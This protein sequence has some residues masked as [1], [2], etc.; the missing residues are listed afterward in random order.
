L[1]AVPY[2]ERDHKVLGV[3]CCAYGTRIVTLFSGS[4]YK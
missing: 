1:A 4:F 2:H 3:D